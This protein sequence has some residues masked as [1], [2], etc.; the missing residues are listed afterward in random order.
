MRRGFVIIIFLLISSLACG[1]VSTASQVPQASSTTKAQATSN[2]LPQ[3]T[4]TSKPAS[5]EAPL[6]Q[7]TPAPTSEEPTKNSL[8]H[9]RAG[10]RADQRD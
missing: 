7:G 8:P 1:F 2:T 5:T 10:C 3:V 4:A 6:P 9:F